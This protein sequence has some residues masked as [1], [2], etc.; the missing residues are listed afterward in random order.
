MLIEE[1]K[2]N[3]EENILLYLSF[4]FPNKQKK[5]LNELNSLV[6]NSTCYLPCYKNKWPSKSLFPLRP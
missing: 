3:N 2:Q 1:N 4:L 5:F 6:A